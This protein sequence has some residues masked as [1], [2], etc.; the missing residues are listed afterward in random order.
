MSDNKS[1]YLENKILNFLFK[2]TGSPWTAP[3]TVAV[4]LC[5]SPVLDA[6]DGSTIV[7]ANYTGYARK[8][9]APADMN[10]ASGGAI[11]NANAITFDA[12]TAGSS[13]IVAIAICDSSTIGAGNVLYYGTVTSK[14]IDTSNTPATIA[15]SGLTVSEQ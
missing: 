10:A 6:D 9:I 11:S 13:T 5:R 15:V 12:C 2:G 1:D 4:A 3:A 7:E 8:V 14:V